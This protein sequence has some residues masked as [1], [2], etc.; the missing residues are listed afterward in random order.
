[1]TDRT[2]EIVP[3]NGSAQGAHEVARA[4]AHLGQS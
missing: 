2:G 4:V 1:V 3:P